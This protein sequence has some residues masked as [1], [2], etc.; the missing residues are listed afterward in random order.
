VIQDRLVPAD[1]RVAYLYHPTYVASAF[2]MAYLLKTLEAC[3]RFDGF[4]ETL[5]KRLKASTA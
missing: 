2:L 1:V 5:F 4:R 3:E